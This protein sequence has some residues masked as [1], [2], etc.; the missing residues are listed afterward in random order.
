MTVQGGLFMEGSRV[1]Q[2][3]VSREDDTLEQICSELHFP[4]MTCEQLMEECVQILALLL[5]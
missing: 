4:L 2:F 5:L 3:V 1:L